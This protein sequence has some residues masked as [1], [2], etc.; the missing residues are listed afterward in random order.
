MPIVRNGSVSTGRRDARRSA[1]LGTFGG[2]FAPSI[3]TILGI[4]LFRRLGFVVGSI[5]LFQALVMLALAT[6]ISVLTSISLSAI[7]TNRKVKGG[8]DYYLISRTLGVEFGGAIGLILYAAQ[9]VSVAF[10]C[11]G[12]G[13]G[14]ESLVGGSEIVVRGSAAIAAV[15]LFA[16]AYSGADLATRFQYVIMLILGGALVSFFAGA[17]N[18]FSLT[19]LEQGWEGAEEGLPFWTVFAILFPAVTGFTQGVSMSGDL[20]N[21]AKSLPTGTF[22]AVGLSTIVYVAAMLVLAGS[23]S[24]TE[25]SNDYDSLKRVA[26]I[27]WLIDLGVLS[28]TLSSALASFLGAPRILQALASDRLF[29]PLT[30]FATG[31][32]PTQNPRR[33]V[34][35]TGVIALATIAIGD[36]NAIATLVSMFF[37]VSYGLLNYATYVEAV[38]AS[39]SFRPRFR[40]FHARASLVGTGLC[41]LVM[42]M[43]DP[44]A[45]AVALGILG[46]LY[47]YVRWTAADMPWRDSR[48]TY[49]F[50]RVKDGLRELSADPESPTDWQPHV[51]V[52]TEQPSRRERLLKAAGWITGGS[53]ILTA[54]QL[55]EGDGAAP[56][57]QKARDDAESVLRDELEEHGLDAYPLVVAAPDLRVGAAT[58]LQ[59]WGVGPIQSNTVLLNWYDSRNTES[60]PTLSL[61]YARLLQRAARLGQHV[62]VLD[63]DDQ[64]WR[65]LE[66][67]RPSERRIDVWWFGGDSSRLALLFA[68]LMTRTDDWDEAKIRV[69]EPVPTTSAKK[70]EASLRRRLEEL[71]IDAEVSVVDTQDGPDLYAASA[72]AS[73]VLIPLRLEGMSTLHPTGGPVDELFEPLPV[74]AMVA[75]CGDVKLTPDEDESVTPPD[76][77]STPADAPSETNPTS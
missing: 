57:V 60:L 48:R 13:E 26:V 42:L 70:S 47:H 46:G 51:L 5:G 65:T 34:V 25:L 15:G 17:E 76:D 74:V 16:L 59:S 66:A 54:V 63:A 40:F 67:S 24:S 43:I 55:I 10:Y 4:I 22:L 27:P 56:A 44:T 64:D 32:G 1:G 20:K 39:P 49:R 50:K 33:G 9:A 45:S 11:V 58:L 18:S 7:A 53:G 75:A 35:I 37:L 41:G 3:L 29:K 38:G 36:L 69:L 72:D 31:H 52:F 61:W 62:V 30:Y 68:Y 2:V 19:V 28:A 71:R 21:P 12:F 77:T 14:V 8:G 73:F 6:L 23:V